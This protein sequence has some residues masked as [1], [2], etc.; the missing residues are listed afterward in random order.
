MY[1]TLLLS[2]NKN[3]TYM[4]EKMFDLFLMNKF[5]LLSLVNVAFRN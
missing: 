5:C 4:L 3:Q 2:I 1:T